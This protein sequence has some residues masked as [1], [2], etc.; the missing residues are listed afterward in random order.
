MNPTTPL[1]P[2][3][4]NQ[5]IDLLDTTAHAGKG[6]TTVARAHKRAVKLAQR[7]MSTAEYAIGILAAVTFA[8]VLL[9]IFND[10]QFFKTSFDVVLKV[11]GW[12]SD[13]II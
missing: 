5:G 6:A 9:R 11:M 4:A 8:L 12:V 13:K 1:Q 3:G 10:N 7:G 2:T